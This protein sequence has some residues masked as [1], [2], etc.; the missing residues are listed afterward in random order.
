M[1]YGANLILLLVDFQLPQYHLLNGLGILIKNQLI[2][3]IDVWVY[4]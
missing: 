3:T 1:K 4:F 2:L